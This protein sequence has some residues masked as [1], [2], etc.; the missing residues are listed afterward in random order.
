[1]AGSLNRV[2]IIGNLTK[3]PEVVSMKNGGEIVKLNIATSESWKSKDGEK[4][5]KTEFHNVVIFTEGL[6][7]VAKSYLNKGSKVFLEGSLQTSKYQKNGVDTY[8]TSIVLQGF[9][10]K[11]ILLGGNKQGG[12]SNNGNSYQSDKNYGQAYEIQKPNDPIPF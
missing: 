7:R 2:T 11:I 8:S 6:A 4:K 12:S 3:D 1:M 5:E 10:G 9:D